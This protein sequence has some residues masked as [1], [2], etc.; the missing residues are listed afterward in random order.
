MIRYHPKKS[1]IL[2]YKRNNTLFKNILEHVKV[3]A[4]KFFPPRFIIAFVS[5]LE[6][7]QIQSE[8]IIHAWCHFE[9][10]HVPILPIL[11]NHP[12]YLIYKFLL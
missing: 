5:D 11:G 9:N 3:R 2:V 7:I 10:C 4:Y 8:D 6:L 1:S 12:S